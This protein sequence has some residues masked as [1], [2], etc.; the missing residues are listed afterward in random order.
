MAARRTTMNI[1][2]ELVSRAQEILGT[3]TATATVHRALDEVIRRF[4]IEQL[5]AWEFPDGFWNETKARRRPR[6]EWK[7]RDEPEAADRDAS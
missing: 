4:H 7:E 2:H 1:D 5:L 3:E 6:Q